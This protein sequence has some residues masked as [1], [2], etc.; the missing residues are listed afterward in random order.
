[1]KKIIP[2]K[3]GRYLIAE[4]TVDGKKMVY[5]NIYAP[6][7]PKHRAQFF[8]EISNSYLKMYPNENIV[9]ADETDCAM[10]TM[11]KRGGKPVDEMQ[12]A[13]VE[14][15]FFMKTHSLIDAWRFKNPQSFGFTWSNPSMKIQCRLDFFFLYQ[16][17]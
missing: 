17:T 1:M 16:N 4:V 2:E 15:Q 6:N 3:H 11:D 5:M 14:L 13:V 10:N 7:E 8:R 9:L 12:Q